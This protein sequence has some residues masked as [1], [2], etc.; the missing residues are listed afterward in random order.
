MQPLQAIEKTEYF[1]SCRD[2]SFQTQRSDLAFGLVKINEIKLIYW[3]NLL[4]PFSQ[5]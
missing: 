5:N 2:R 4:T 1:P 3:I